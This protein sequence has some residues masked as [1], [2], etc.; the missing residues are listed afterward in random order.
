MRMDL[1]WRQVSLILGAAFLS[2]CAIERHSFIRCLIPGVVIGAGLGAAAGGGENAAI[3]A[4]GGGLVNEMICA[5][6]LAQDSEPDSDADGVSDSIDRCAHT[7]E[8]AQ[9]FKPEALPDLGPAAPGVP[10]AQA[11]DQSGCPRTG[12][13][14]LR[15]K[16]VG[17]EG[18][19]DRITRDSE[20]M[21]DQAALVLRSN[22]SLRVRIELSPSLSPLEPPLAINRQRAIRDYFA[23][24]GILP[25][26]IQLSE[27]RTGESESG[28]FE[29]IQLRIVPVADR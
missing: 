11:V 18:N 26:R 19:T 17:F 13:L 21:L 8:G 10:A 4:L 6:V 12:Q 16:G 14:L 27:S 25:E 23:L 15:L 9:V 28:H 20:P 22:P 24:R 1:R 3:G 2:G 7:P 5:T 29:G